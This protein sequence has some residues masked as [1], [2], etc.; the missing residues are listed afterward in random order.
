MCHRQIKLFKYGEFINVFGSNTMITPCSI[1]FLTK[2]ITTFPRLHYKY[3]LL[4]YDGRIKHTI[5]K[6]NHYCGMSI[7]NIFKTI[8][9]SANYNS[10]DSR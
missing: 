7:F 2:K 9:I 5:N 4:I 8:T 3:S 1:V 6:Q 10:N